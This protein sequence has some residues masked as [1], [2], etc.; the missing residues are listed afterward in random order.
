MVEVDCD[1]GESRKGGGAL[2]EERKKETTNRERE[3]E[4][5]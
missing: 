2:F 1:N 5:F 4:A 3:R